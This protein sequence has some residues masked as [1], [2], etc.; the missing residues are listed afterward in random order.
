MC[1]VSLNR[2]KLFR[3]LDGW[4]RRRLRTA[5]SYMVFR[6]RKIARKRDRKWTTKSA[7]RAARRINWNP[8]WT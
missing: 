2:W 3:R 1:Y 7:Q 4:S 8:R 6:V 5:C